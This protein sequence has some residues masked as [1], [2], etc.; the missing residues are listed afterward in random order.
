MQDTSSLPSLS[1]KPNG[2]SCCQATQGS[3]QDAAGPCCGGEQAGGCCSSQRQVPP[4]PPSSQDPSVSPQHNA[5]RQYTLPSGKTLAEDVCILYIG[6]ESLTLTDLLL[7]HSSTPVISYDPTADVAKL[8]SS[9]TNKLL[10]KRYGVVQKARDADVIGIVVGTLGVSSYLP[11]LEYVRKLIKKHKKKSYTMAVGKLTPAKLGNFLEIESWVLVACG[12]N[13]MVETYKEFMK[14]IITPWELEVALGE[15][16]WITG[17][18]QEGRYTLDF[19]RV[20]QDSRRV[21]ERQNETG[22]NDDAKVDGEERGDQEDDD[23]D[24]PVFSTV[25]GQY[26][27]RKTYGGKEDVKGMLSLY[28]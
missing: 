18:T 28:Y 24:A 1:G 4:P 22:L 23:P 5:C 26:R 17:G 2:S 3:T 9:R 8:E 20:L 14:P 6:P 25:T 12:E 21:E 16:E 27:Y 7:S 11:T 19:A 10:M 15:R 13:S